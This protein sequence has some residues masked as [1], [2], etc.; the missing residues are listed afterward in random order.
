MEESDMTEGPEGLPEGVVVSAEGAPAAPVP[1]RFGR[2]NGELSPEKLRIDRAARPGW[3]TGAEQLPEVGEEVYCTEG[4][5]S[6]V[7]LLGHTGDGSRLL[8]LRLPGAEK[9]PFFAAASN[10]LV[11]PR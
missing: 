3:P 1:F 4:M 8:E 2:R 9:H 5:G 11:A 10:V 6:V 7:R